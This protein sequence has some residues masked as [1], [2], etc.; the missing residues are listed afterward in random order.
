MP[1]R[2]AIVAVR[3]GSAFGADA[4]HEDGRGDA[5]NQQS[6]RAQLE[7]QAIELRVRMHLFGL[8]RH[9]QDPSHAGDQ[10]DEEKRLGG[11]S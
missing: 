3:V 10:A 5:Y 11:D 1:N 9:D 7:Q 8:R 6:Q 2:S 4:N